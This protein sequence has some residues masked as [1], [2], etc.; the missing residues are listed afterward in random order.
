MTKAKVAVIADL[1]AGAA[2]APAPPHYD[3][4]ADP[5][6]PLRRAL[7]KNNVCGVKKYNPT[8]II[9]VGDMIDGANKKNAGIQCIST[10][11][12]TQMDIAVSTLKFMGNKNTIFA[13]VSGTPYHV[14]DGVD[15][16]EEVSKR[17]GYAK[18][19]LHDFVEINGVV[20]NVKHKVGSSSV[21]HGRN[22]SINRSKLWEQIW[23]EYYDH[24]KSDVLIRGHVHYHA[25]HG[26][27]TYLAMSLPAMCGM[28]SDFGVR[29]C[30]GRVDSGW[31]QFDIDEDGRYTWQAHVTK[32][33]EQ[34][35]EVTKL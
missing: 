4:E 14:C 28:G 9:T 13:G 24:P 30:E 18:F 7:W 29:Q 1:H 32:I 22:T 35:Q 17:V 5:F 8:H 15:A 16:D 27:H 6:T 23:A 12:T 34:K 11:L 3:M 20:F 19:G 26:D 31:V 33:V 10:D 21:P 2:W 25:Y